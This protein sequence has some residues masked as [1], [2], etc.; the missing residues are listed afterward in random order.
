MTVEH[1]Y[2][3]FGANLGHRRDTYNRVLKEMTA[4]GFE[5]LRASSLYET[6]PWGGVEGGPFLNAVIEIARTGE[7]E[8]ALTRL[9]NIE[10]LFGRQR[11]GINAARTCD[12]DLLLW[13]NAIMD[14]AHLM[15]PHPRFHLRRFTLVPLCDL[16]SDFDHPVLHQTF[17]QLLS[18]CTDSLTVKLIS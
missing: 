18:S 14:T 6:E 15:L 3:G 2:V 8:T 5:I 1:G 17:G 11:A 10:E 16:I 12:L 13:G 9:Q 7:P 4:A